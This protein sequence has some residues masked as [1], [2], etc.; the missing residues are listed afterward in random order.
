M[1]RTFNPLAAYGLVT[2]PHEGAT[3]YQDGGYFGPNGK[4]LF[5]DRPPTPP[6]AVVSESTTV[7]SAT[8]ETVTTTTVETVE[9]IVPGDPREILK[10]WLLG[11]VP[12]AFPTAVKQVKLAFNLVLTNK[13][14]I[15]DYL[16]NTARLVPA[17]LVK[18]S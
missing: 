15:I 7:D 12:L 18:V 14:E 6:K 8:G 4:L 1:A 9:E 13:A 16:V 2:P 5:E 17:E 3:H 11:E 10:G